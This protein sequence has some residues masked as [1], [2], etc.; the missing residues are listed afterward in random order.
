MASRKRMS[1]VVRHV[2]SGCV[3]RA[4]TLS[5][6]A[7]RERVSLERRDHVKCGGTEEY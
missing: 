1:V 6:V 5:G 2:W 4:F 3:R 7:T